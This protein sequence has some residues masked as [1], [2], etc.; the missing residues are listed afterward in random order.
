MACLQDVEGWAL[1]EGSKRLC[2][3]RDSPHEPRGHCGLTDLAAWVC[4]IPQLR[5]PIRSLGLS[6]LL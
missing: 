1:Q 6:Y 4:H 5:R 2:G 3:F